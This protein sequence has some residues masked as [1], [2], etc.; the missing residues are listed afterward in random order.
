MSNTYCVFCF[1]CLRI[2]SCLSND[3]TCHGYVNS[4][5]P[6]RFSLTFIKNTFFSFDVFMI[7]ITYFRRKPWYIIWNLYYNL[8]HA[9][10][11]N[12]QNFVESKSKWVA[13]G[14]HF[15]HVTKHIYHVLL[16]NFGFSCLSRLIFDTRGICNT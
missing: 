10:L 13:N 12:H 14:N 1:V 3:V 16:V 11:T 15:I 6:L 9:L 4:W 7:Y 8:C 5:L 2:V